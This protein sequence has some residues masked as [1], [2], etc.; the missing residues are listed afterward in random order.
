MTKWLCFIIAQ[1]Y[2]VNT[3]KH[4]NVSLE[5]LELC[6]NGFKKK[7]KKSLALAINFLRN[8]RL[9]LFWWSVWNKDKTKLTMFI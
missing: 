4:K 8:S 3:L 7:K 9:A 2:N 5:Y 1:I 6:T